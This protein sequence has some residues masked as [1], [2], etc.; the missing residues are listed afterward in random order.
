[1]TPFLAS[2]VLSAHKV[3]YSVPS[4]ITWRAQ[5]GQSCSLGKH[6]ITIVALGTTKQHFGETTTSRRILDASSVFLKA[7]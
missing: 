1:M 4:K 7:Y 3:W 6:H 5:H 2:V